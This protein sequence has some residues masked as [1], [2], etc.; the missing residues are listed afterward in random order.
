L[1]S[2]QAPEDDLKADQPRYGDKD[3]Y[4]EKGIVLYDPA[5]TRVTRYRHRG[6]SIPTPWTTRP[7]S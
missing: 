1:A 6:A 2:Q 7:D 3:S 4:H 5:K